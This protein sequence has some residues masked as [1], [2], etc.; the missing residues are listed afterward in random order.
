MRPLHRNRCTGGQDAALQ[1]AQL[2]R[3]GNSAVRGPQ[4]CVMQC[5]VGPQKR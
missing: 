4:Q 5:M 1:G 2:T 3:S